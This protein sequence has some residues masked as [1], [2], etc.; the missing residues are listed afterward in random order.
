MSICRNTNL[1]EATSA[2]IAQV[3]PTDIENN[4]FVSV[5]E[6]KQFLYGVP[7]SEQMRRR[8]VLLNSDIGFNSEYANT[9][10]TALSRSAKFSIP[11]IVSHI[12]DTRKSIQVGKKIMPIQEASSN[13]IINYAAEQFKNYAEAEGNYNVQSPEL[14]NAFSFLYDFY[15]KVDGYADILNS[16]LVGNA[17]A[18]IKF[19]SAAAKDVGGKKAPYLIKE[20]SPSQKAYLN[21]SMTGDLFHL[22]GEDAESSDL[23]AQVILKEDGYRDTLKEMYGK[24]GSGPGT[25]Y[26][27][28]QDDLKGR[29]NQIATSHKK[30]ISSQR[31]AQLVREYNSVKELIDIVKDGQVQSLGL[32]GKNWDT[33]QKNHLVY[34]SRFD[35]NLDTEAIEDIATDE[36]QDENEVN[37]RDSLGIT[38]A[39]EVNPI[40]RL[41]REVKA[42]L[43]TLPEVKGWSEK[44]SKFVFEQNKLGGT[45]LADYSKVQGI[46]YKALSNKESLDAKISALQK[47]AEQNYTFQI[48]LDRLG[49]QEGMNLGDLTKFQMQVFISLANSFNNAGHTYNIVQVTEGGARNVMNAN[50]E[51]EHNAVKRLWRENFTYAVQSSIG[52]VNNKKQRVLNLNTKING[53]SLKERLTKFTNVNEAVELL[54]TLGVQFTNPKNVIDEIKRNPQQFLT[55]AKV[56]FNQIVVKEGDIENVFNLD[57]G[58]RFNS[59]IELEL[60]TSD[61]LGTLSFQG[62][63]GSKIYGVSLKGFN[64]VM[65]DLIA[66]DSSTKQ[67]MLKSPTTTN[68][69]WLKGNNRIEVATLLGTVNTENQFSASVDRAGLADTAAQEISSILSGHVPFIKAGN[70][71]THTTLKFEDPNYSKTKAQFADQLLG[72]LED[73]VVTAHAIRHGAASQIKGLRNRGSKLQLF[74]H[75]HFESIEGFTETLIADKTLTRKDISK[76]LKDPIVKNAINKYIL[77]ETGTI[78]KDL[79]DF[80]IIRKNTKGFYTN[81]GLDSNQVQAIKKVLQDNSP[82]TSILSKQLANK[83]AEQIFMIRTESLHEQFKVFL[84]HPAL[85]KD[86]FKRTSGLIGPKKYPITD[87]GVLEFVKKEYPPLVNPNRYKGGRDIGTVR[88]VTRAEVVETS[89]Y[90]Q[91][92]VNTLSS[93]K[94]DPSLKKLIRDTYSNMEIFDGGGFINLDFYRLTRRL[95]DSWSQAHEDAYNNVIND[96][97]TPEDI[98]K[99][100]PIK[101]QVFA[102]ALEDNIDIRIFNKFALFP[103]H[104]NLSKVVGQDV[105]LMMEKIHK[106]MVDNN[107]DYMVMESATKVGPK[108]RRDGEFDT[109]VDSNNVYTPLETDEAVQEYNLNFFGIQMDPKGK[110]SKDVSMGTQSLAMLLTNVF[111]NT[112]LAA[113]YK[114]APFSKDETWLEAANRFHRLNGTIIQRETQELANKLGYAYDRGSNTFKNLGL[115]VSKDLMRDTILDELD[116]RDVSRLMRD[117]IIN[118]FDG[119]VNLLNQIPEKSRLET[120]VNAIVTNSVIRRKMNGDMVVLQSNFGFEVTNE[121]KKQKDAP[122]EIQ[123]MGKLKFY[124]K[125][126][127]P[128]S[129]TLAMQVYLPHSFKEFL[130]Q[131]VPEDLIDLSD[132]RIK[133]HIGFRIPTEGLNSVEFMEVIGYLPQSAGSTIIVPSEMV[134][135]SGADFDIDKLTLYIPNTRL[136]NGKLVLEPNINNA[137]ELRERDLGAYKN[138]IFRLFDESTAVGL[139]KEITELYKNK[140]TAQD[141]LNAFKDH[142]AIKA[143]YN[144]IQE[145]KEDREGALTNVEKRNISKQITDIY[146]SINSQLITTPEGIFKG[147]EFDRGTLQRFSSAVSARLLEIDQLVENEGFQDLPQSEKDTKAYLQNELQFFMKDVLRHPQSFDQLIT[148]VGAHGLKEMAYRIDALK[149]SDN[150]VDPEA[151]ILEEKP[152]KLLDMLSF[153]NIIETTRTMYQ[154]LG[155]TGI[156]ATSMTHAIKLQKSGIAFSKEHIFNFANVHPGPEHSLS[157]INS[158]NSTRTINSEMQQYVTGYV[159]GEKDPFVMYVNAGKDA[160]AIHMVLLRVG[161]PLEDVLYFMSQPIIT[162]FLR[163]KS[164][165]QGVA[166][167]TAEGGQYY[168]SDD[169]IVKKLSHGQKY[170]QEA[171][172]SPTGAPIKFE[173]DMLKSMVGKTLENKEYSKQLTP[174]DKKRQRAILNDFLEYK[175]YAEEIRKLQE[176]HSYDKVKLKNGSENIY[177][178]AMERVINESGNFTNPMGLIKDPTSMLKYNRD[179]LYASNTLLGTVDLK[180]SNPQLRQFFVHKA[181][182]LINNGIRRDDVIYTLNKFDNF[183]TAALIQNVKVDGNQ[184]IAD[185][186]Y[187]LM[188]GETSLPRRIKNL[189]DSGEITNLALDSLLPILD[190]YLQGAVEATSDNLKLRRGVF[191]IT[192]TDIIA[193]EMRQLK[194]EAPAIYRDL[195]YFSMLQSGVDFNPN[196]FYTVLPSE[197]ILPITNAAFDLFMQHPSPH[198]ELTNMWKN[199]YDANW[200][201]NVIT[202]IRYV[203]SEGSKY[204]MLGQEEIEAKLLPDIQQNSL[205]LKS[206]AGSAH[207]VRATQDSNWELSSKKGIKSKS[208]EATDSESMYL[209]NRTAKITDEYK[210]GPEV[211]KKI[212]AGY[213]IAS[214]DTKVLPTGV[215]ILQDGTTIQVNKLDKG[216]GNINQLIKNESLLEYLNEESLSKEQLASIIGYNSLA[217]M[218]NSPKYKGFVS[219]KNKLYL[220]TI[221]VIAPG[222][223][224]FRVE[225]N[226]EEEN[227][228]NVNDTLFKIKQESKC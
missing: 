191:N 22:L 20:I 23:L 178:E 108:T 25:V 115:D 145:L 37:T 2:A 151:D 67:D 88:Y 35:V 223:G 142:P 77:N 168:L 16:T 170:G 13:D 36:V 130:G 201:N 101:P 47:L 4:P 147:Q 181:M 75:K 110:R 66:E 188:Q 73:E 41:S 214:L 84:G 153:K 51:G 150:Y 80:N 119:D 52:K 100:D 86:L 74:D 185:K 197:D 97:A 34:M 82:S 192:D 140:K 206:P 90:I 121:A 109:F 17:T 225:E 216:F 107:L 131:E 53:K 195:I 196:A 194:K 64:D 50:K 199:F 123:E 62:I 96:T 134:A 112:K 126:N 146:E 193:D 211:T 11:S 177:M 167:R 113:R 186:R 68:S 155:G 165:N 95:T 203:G 30:E 79:E 213:K 135:K 157:R 133:E 208:V 190:T 205:T 57:L 65:S 111:D 120:I 102:Q 69:V 114:N 144:K 92:Y 175:K 93:L 24:P 143:Q 207:Y 58:G 152:K 14:N 54:R 183:I 43:Q 46:M 154:T 222:N 70:K 210:A 220:S 200:D 60:K 187:S 125:D 8:G 164:L 162:D 10:A 5:E 59:L 137:Q 38:P 103:V 27:Q 91:E 227:D 63:D 26:Y 228:G 98:A 6:F 15:S 81:I 169:D 149:N 179:S 159:D 42:I 29:L 94:S 166:L 83:I 7:F 198:T 180:N 217:E 9:F 141:F 160:A 87:R 158:F 76:A 99:L 202:K 212:V 161:V 224:V 139:I 184:T 118:L 176:I 163:M 28:L 138:V 218:K 3:I 39:H 105:P 71:K 48:L 56:I 132:P 89:S 215:Y 21:E 33:I 19:D 49:F 171:A 182:E 136:V 31:K 148:P 226:I 221:E 116:R 209:S 122:K 219:G 61:Q 104:P 85:Y 78:L 124:R 1:F 174:M 173:L 204:K 72:Y 127:G 44:H 32:I 18:E 40:S 129:N 189:Q 128:N 156:V 172:M 106:D 117:T 12:K 45:K 55:N